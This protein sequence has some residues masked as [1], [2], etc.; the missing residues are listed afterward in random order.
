LSFFLHFKASVTSTHLFE[1]GL[2]IKPVN[3][4]DKLR[5]EVAGILV[6]GV[7]IDCNILLGWQK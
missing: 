5:T 7:D 3:F 4:R 1:G 6:S 2:K